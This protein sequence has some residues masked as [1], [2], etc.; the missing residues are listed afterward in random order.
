MKKALIAL[1]L[2]LAPGLA[3]GQGGML[4]S[5]GVSSSAWVYGQKVLIA[6][7]GASITV[8]SI[9]VTLVNGACTNKVALYSDFGLTVPIPNPTTLDAN[10]NYSFYA[11][12]TVLQYT[13]TLKGVSSGPFFVRTPGQGG[14]GGTGTG[15]TQPPYTQFFN[16]Q[17][18]LT[19][20][21]SV[22]GY[23]TMGLIAACYDN[24]SPAHKIE[25]AQLY[26]NTLTYDVTVL[27]AS[28]QSGLC[29]V[30]G[31]APADNGVANA[32]LYPGS[33]CGA[34]IN[35]ADSAYAGIPIEI[36]VNHA[37][38]T[39]WTTLVTLSA[40]H[41]LRFVQGGTYTTNAG[42]VL[43]GQSSSIS[44]QPSAVG[45]SAGIAP[46][47]LKAANGAGLS[48]VLTLG[49]GWGTIAD[50]ITVDAN[51]ANGGTSS[52]GVA[53]KVDRSGRFELRHTTATNA[54]SH[55]FWI[56]SSG[57]NN[58]SCCGKMDTIFALS[59]GG[60]GMLITN[61]G[62]LFATNSEFEINT[63]WGIDGQGAAT[64][65]ITHS[66]IGGNTAGGIRA[67]GT[68]A[69]TSNEMQI[70]NTQFGGNGGH[71]FLC[72]GT[73]I[74]YSSWGHV[75]SNNNFVGGGYANRLDNTFD[76]VHC[77]DGQATLVGNVIES[78]GPNRYKY[79][80]SESNP[81]FAQIPSSVVGNSFNVGGFGTKALNVYPSTSVAG[82]MDLN[83]TA[84]LLQSTVF[85][86]NSAVKSLDTSN[87]P[88]SLMWM[89]SDNNVYLTGHPAQKVVVLRG[90]PA[91][92]LLNL[93]SNTV[94]LNKSAFFQCTT[95]AG[96][97][98]VCLSTFGSPNITYL[99]GSGQIHLQP[100]GGNDMFVLDSLTG[101]SVGAPIATSSSMSAGT[102]INALTG[103]EFNGTAGYTGTKT[104][105]SCVLTIQGGI[106]TNV[107]GC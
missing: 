15:T 40:N 33:D 32:S 5:D 39:A 99:L 11:A 59:N 69:F 1:L 71:D 21:G 4:A 55:G 101:L 54:M 45:G 36:D 100:V 89:G 52:S 13:V 18:T 26:V 31:G 61:T 102:F 16:G 60:S 27:F 3:F 84:N 86:N 78:S 12:S 9:P 83:S 7:P 73:A 10:S 75:L 24:A 105:G 103:F 29:V 94:T 22:H 81:N 63:G 66:D 35:A 6:I 44:G 104:A 47:T 34:K 48:A 79:G 51:K 91:T 30:N 70:S 46:I 96:A 107:T 2:L 92:D 106:I 80:F 65:R 97:P 87:I 23:R 82:N 43:S 17:T 53:I 98:Y 42:V 25:P 38:G 95:S 76:A 41:L 90:D 67:L 72:D 57:I 58:E 77:V 56:Y 85:P 20:P 62:D 50:N 88:Q 19:I 28:P 93:G 74:Y 14:S 64:L 49:P 68:T 8:C 37:C